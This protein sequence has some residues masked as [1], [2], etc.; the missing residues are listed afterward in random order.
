VDVVV[1]QQITTV[2]VETTLFGSS[3]SYPVVAVGDI[4]AVVLAMTTA[5]SGS[6]FCS[7]AAAAGVETA[8][9][10]AVNF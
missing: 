10:S 2:D 4:T 6:F 1:R 7:S 9:V 3:C 5:V 8:A